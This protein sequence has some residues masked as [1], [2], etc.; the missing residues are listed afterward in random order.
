MSRQGQSI[1]EK[2]AVAS[3]PPVPPPVFDPEPQLIV[4]ETRSLLQHANSAQEHIVAT[5]VPH[6]ATF[7]N[8]IIPYVQEENTRLCERQRIEFLA[9]TFPDEAIRGA[10]REAADLFSRFD[11]KTFQRRDLYT[12]VAA[13]SKTDEALTSEQGRL[14]AKLRGD[15]ERNG[16]GLLKDRQTQLKQIEQELRQLENAYL[17]T[18]RED[19]GIW[20]G[21]DELE[22]VDPSLVAELP[23]GTEDH[24]GKLRLSLRGM[25]CWHVLSTAIREETRKNVYLARAFECTPNVAKLKRAN[26]LRTEKAHLLGYKSFAVLQMSN[27]MEK[28]PQKIQTFLDVLLRRLSPLRDS[29]VTRWRHMKSEDLK[30]RGEHDDGGF[31]EWDRHYYSRRMTE[32]DYASKA[33]SLREDF[34]LHETIGHMLGMFE[35]CFGVKFV[36]LD[37]QALKGSF[38]PQNGKIFIWHSTVQVFAVWNEDY[39]ALAPGEF[40]GYLYL[41]LFARTGKRPGFC[42]LPIQPVRIGAWAHFET[43]E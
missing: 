10:S 23:C 15:F 20:L 32:Q 8:T 35:H 25:R 19:H 40:L 11:T 24:L 43:L 33:D 31:Y 17:Q 3:V 18:C 7:A 21:N 27:N 14:L 39:E 9:H 30:R 41:D 38:P 13:A 29:F 4:E 37:E 34:E 28:S 26:V 2:E 36:K 22:G 6:A 42:D 12:L 16:L 1:D 5:V